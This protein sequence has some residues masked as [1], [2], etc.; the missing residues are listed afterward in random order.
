MKIFTFILN[1]S[2]LDGANDKKGLYIL[3]SI[4]N[5]NKNL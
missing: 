5:N 4:K 2:W 3:F 1:K